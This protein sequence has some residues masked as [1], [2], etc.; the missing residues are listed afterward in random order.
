MYGQQQGPSMPPYVPVGSPAGPKPPKPGPTGTGVAIASA[1]V[2]GAVLVA[3]LLVRI[4]WREVGAFN[5]W[6]FFLSLVSV[7]FIFVVY[8]F[9]VGR[10][11]MGKLVGGGL[12]AFSFLVVVGTVVL[13]LSIDSNG[14]VPSGVYDVLDALSVVTAVAAWG[15]A[16]RSGWLWSVSIPIS[17]VTWA[18]YRY[19]IVDL[20]SDPMGPRT[21]SVD[22]WMF[23]VVPWLL[24]TTAIPI[25][26]GWGLELLTRT[27]S[28]NTR[29]GPGAPQA[30]RPAAQMPPQPQQGHWQ[31]HPGP[32]QVQRPQAPQQPPSHPP[33]QG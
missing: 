5:H 7:D 14:A 13:S 29:P 15:I 11:T 20:L 31:W 24:I 25:L 28:S 2:F 17:L 9:V 22:Q 19:V 12:Q 16:R 30:P 1:A 26:I 8:L 21:D 3:N 6:A 32:Q 33:R 18:L 4:V 27:A 23:N 10:G